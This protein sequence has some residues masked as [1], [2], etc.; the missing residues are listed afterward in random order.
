MTR[1]MQW[2]GLI[3]DPARYVGEAVA[4]EAA[5]A[6]LAAMAAQPSLPQG[7][8]TW[9]ASGTAVWRYRIAGPIAGGP[10]TV[11]DVDAG[12]GSVIRCATPPR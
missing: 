7:E 4:R 12:N 2:L 11:L 1:L 8:L 10:E 3:P 6:Y 5:S 9:D